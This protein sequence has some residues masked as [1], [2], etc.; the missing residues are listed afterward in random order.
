VL[1]DAINVT[2]AST[3]DNAGRCLSPTSA[4][5]LQHEHP[6]NRLTP[7]LQNA[8]RHLSAKVEGSVDA[9][10]PAS[11][12]LSTHFLLRSELRQWKGA[13]DRTDAALRW[14]VSASRRARKLDL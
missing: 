3:A 4:T 8:F 9:V 2:L 12:V 5:D 13:P 14:R 10:L 6:Q 11:A 1:P 7:L